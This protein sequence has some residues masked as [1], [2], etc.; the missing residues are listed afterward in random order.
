MSGKGH[1]TWVVPKD[2]YEMTMKLAMLKDVQNPIDICAD[3]LRDT[4]AWDLDRL[5]RQKT[6][7]HSIKHKEKYSWWCQKCG[8]ELVDY[9]CPHEN[10]RE[11]AQWGTVCIDCEA[12]IE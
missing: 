1:R 7:D 9:V 5:E 11:T 3:I 12:V 8:L 4:L 2:I 10:T 6:C